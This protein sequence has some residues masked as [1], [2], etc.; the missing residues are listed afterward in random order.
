MEK[1]LRHNP[2]S[3]KSFEIG[4]MWLQLLWIIFRISRIKTLISQFVSLNRMLWW[5][6]S[7]CSLWGITL[8][9][10]YHREKC[11][12]RAQQ[13]TSLVILHPHPNRRGH[14]LGNSLLLWRTVIFYA[15]DF[16]ACDT[17]SWYFSVIE[18]HANFRC[19]GCLKISALIIII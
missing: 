16:G 6:L 5:D 18:Q 4:H 14:W 10:L 8:T 19:S 13:Y 15:W 7:H 2:Y 11:F 9:Y 1:H 12:W 3:L 17:V